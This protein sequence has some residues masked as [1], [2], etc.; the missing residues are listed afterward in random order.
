MGCLYMFPPQNLGTMVKDMVKD[1]A[2]VP[3]EPEVGEDQSEAMSFRHDRTTAVG[4]HSMCVSLQELPFQNPSM[5]WEGVHEAIH[6]LYL[7]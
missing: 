7:L 4:T 6:P 3:E 1:E 2:E 5:R